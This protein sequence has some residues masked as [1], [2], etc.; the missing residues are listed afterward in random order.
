MSK[1]D[2]NNYNNSPP[3]SYEQVMQ[4]KAKIRNPHRTTQTFVRTSTSGSSS[5]QVLEYEISKYAYSGHD[6]T[7]HTTLLGAIGHLVKKEHKRKKKDKKKKN[8]H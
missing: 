1:N 4:D 3:P 7:D 6:F 5:L 2:F 8:K